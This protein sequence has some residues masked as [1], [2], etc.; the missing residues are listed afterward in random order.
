MR[1]ELYH[2][3]N[4]RSWRTLDWYDYDRAAGTVSRGNRGIFG[5]N[6]EH[7]GFRTNFVFDPGDGERKLRTSLGF[8]VNDVTFKRAVNFGGGKS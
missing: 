7:D 1:S 8:E 4:D 2:L 6:V 3:D 5:H